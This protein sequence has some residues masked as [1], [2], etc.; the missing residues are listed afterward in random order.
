MTIYQCRGRFTVPTADL[1]ARVHTADKSAVGTVNRP[2]RVISFISI[3]APTARAAALC[4]SIR[5]CPDVFIRL[6]K[7]PL[8]GLK[9]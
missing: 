2:L 5:L 6:Y 3:I 4:Q 9:G 1:S 7:P 8:Q